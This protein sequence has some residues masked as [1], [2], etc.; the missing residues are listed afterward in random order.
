MRFYLRLTVYYL[1]N[2]LPGTLAA[3]GLFFLL[4][5]WRLR[6]LERLG[7]ASAPRRE[8]WLLFL[9]CFA[10][11]L[12]TVTLTPWG[13]HWVTLL[14]YGT[15]SDSGRFFSLGS[16]NLV[17][18]RTLLPETADRFSLFNLLGN[19]LV[20]VP[21]GFLPAMLFRSFSWRRALGTGLCLTVFIELWQLAVG[22]ACDIDDVLLNTLGVLA[23]RWLWQ[24]ADAAAAGRLRRYCSGEEK[25]LRQCPP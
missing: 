13:F 5:P 18:F 1:E 8:G 4:R 14:K 20:F 3:A 6:R 11:A 17:P 21:L 25:E 23:G 24:L 19:C 22:R 12:G 16:V 2:M 10:G 7:L 9:W 15:V